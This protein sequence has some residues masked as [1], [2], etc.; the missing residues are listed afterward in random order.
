MHGEAEGF[1]VEAKQQLARLDMGV[2]G[3]RHV[4]HLAV[5]PWGD[6]QHRA[7]QLRL[8]RDG[9]PQVRRQEVGEQQDEQDDGRLDPTGESLIRSHA[10]LEGA[11]RKGGWEDGNGKTSAFAALGSQ[12]IYPRIVDNLAIARSCLT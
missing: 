12:Y 10:Y 9:H 5:H 11:R 4:Q 8:G 2:V 6:A 3:H 1:G 7:G